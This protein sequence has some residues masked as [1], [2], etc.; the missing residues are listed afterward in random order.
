MPRPIDLGPF[1]RLAGLAA[2][3]ALPGLLSAQHREVEVHVG[4][5]WN[6]GRRAA[7][8]E[9]RTSYPLAGAITHGLAAAVLIDDG[10]GRNRAF[11]G[12]GYELQFYR[13]RAAFAPYAL[14][15]LALGLSTDT[16]TQELGAHWSIGGGVE[17]RP[18]SRFA[19]G[20]EA[21]YRVEDRG[22]R[23][24]WRPGEARKGLSLAAGIALGLGRAGRGAETRLP[25]L[26]LP[27]RIT[28]NAASV[29]QTALDVLGKPYV[30]GGTSQNGFDCSGLIQYAYGS[31]GVRLPRTSR[32]QARVGSAV[33][34]VTQALAPGDILLFSATP[35]SGVTHVGMHVGEGTFIHSS[36]TG[37]KLSRL[38]AGDP[39]GA[40]W[41]ARWVGVR[42]VIQ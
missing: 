12:M 5:W 10:F 14:A 8:Y 9:L 1:Q 24:F 34:P 16:S 23:G 32:D 37:V 28:G 30:W 38:E 33:P 39:D 31:H 22:P 36:T 42:R 15:G 3:L 35:G 29:V 7:S 26:Q 40:W 17:W 2:L 4:G 20:V 18:L 11:Y 13:R 25:P 21:R 6:G 19:L 41:V 27:A